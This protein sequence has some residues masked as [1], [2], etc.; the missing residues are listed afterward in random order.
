VVNTKDD[1]DGML[2]IIT[3]GH[4]WEHIASDGTSIDAVSTTPC[5][6]DSPQLKPNRKYTA[7][8]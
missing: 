5:E 7:I 4:G 2:Q 3:F 1:P 8:L 6:Y